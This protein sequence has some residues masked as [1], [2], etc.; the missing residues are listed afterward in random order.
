MLLFKKKFLEAIRNGEK[1]Q[2][3]R[4]WDRCRMKSG[5]RSYIPGI[6]YIS[7][8]SVEPV[9][10]DRLTDADAIPDGFAD[11]VSLQAELHSIY[12]EE[13]KKGFRAF[14]IRFSVFSE[15]DQLKMQREKEDRKNQDSRKHR[16]QKDLE[17]KEQVDRTLEKLR[18][19]AQNGRDKR[20]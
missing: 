3:I 2:T 10:I 17:K 13:I 14:R 15:E 20:S 6:G 9:E 8:L 16:Q 11:A 5:Q 12:A 7:I 4:L 18:G 1:T 19:L